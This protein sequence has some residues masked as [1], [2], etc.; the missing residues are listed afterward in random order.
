M[1]MPGGRPGSDEPP[2]GRQGAAKQHRWARTL[3]VAGYLLFVYVTTYFILMD[4]TSPAFDPVAQKTRYESSLWFAPSVRT[5]GPFN[6]YVRRSCWANRVFW[7]LDC[8][9]Q[10]VLRP[11]N[12]AVYEQWDRER[13]P[14][15]VEDPLAP[16]EHPRQAQPPKRAAR[17]AL[18]SNGN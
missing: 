10:P 12:R 13:R 3:R 2:A 11:C 15:K 18:P 17:T 9:V 14:A 8:I 4:T 5:P 7:P 6:I 1:T 16:L